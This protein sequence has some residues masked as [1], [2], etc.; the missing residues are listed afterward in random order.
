MMMLQQW[1]NCDCSWEFN[2]S[3]GTGC[4]AKVAAMKDGMGNS[5]CVVNGVQVTGGVD[6]VKRPG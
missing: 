1:A 5:V 6:D 3:K 2:P 4:K